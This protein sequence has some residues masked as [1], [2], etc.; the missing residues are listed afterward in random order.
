MAPV[1]ALVLAAAPALVI[2]ADPRAHPAA[3]APACNVTLQKQSSE[4]KCTGGPWGKFGCFSNDSNYMWAGEGCR[5][6]FLCNGHGNVS[7]GAGFGRKLACPCIPGT[8]PPPPPFPPPPPPPPIP[9]APPAPPGP[10]CNINGTWNMTVGFGPVLNGGLHMSDMFIKQ[11]PGSRNYT[12]H[13]RDGHG[14]WPP[15]GEPAH[16]TVQGYMIG[17][18]SMMPANGTPH[19]NW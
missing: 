17:N 14:T 19:F 18:H 1:L 2:A 6:V 7:C 3:V 11:A 10:L 4:T 8:L 16:P 15:G 12:L 5:G 13:W 9:P